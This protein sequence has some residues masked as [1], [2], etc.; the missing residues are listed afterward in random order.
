MGAREERTREA[1]DRLG[2]PDRGNRRDPHGDADPSRRPDPLPRDR[3]PVR[4]DA[5]VQAAA[6][7]AAL[8]ERDRSGR[9]VLERS[10]GGRVRRAVVRAQPGDVLRDQQ[11][12]ADVRSAPRAGRVGDLGATGLLTDARGHPDRRALRPR[13]RERDRQ[14]EPDGELDE[15]AGV[16][17]P[18]GARPAAQPPVRPGLL[19]DRLCAVHPAALRR[20]AGAGGALGRDREVGVRDPRER[21]G[22]AGEDVVHPGEVRRCEARSRARRTYRTS[23]RPSR[24]FDGT[25]TCPRDG[26][27]AVVEDS[28]P[29]HRSSSPIDDRHR[30]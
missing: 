5:G 23:D 10:P 11:G 8:A 19:L 22:A 3:V 18:E 13:A 15:A 29:S 4:G 26:D 1:G 2:V 16:A 14:G 30:R 6:H 28:H 25:E 17:L 9:R 21:V 20:R 12:P 7:G 27:R 24:R